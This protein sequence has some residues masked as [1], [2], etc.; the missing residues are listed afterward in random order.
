VQTQNASLGNAQIVLTRTPRRRSRSG[1]HQ[2]PGGT[3]LLKLYMQPC[4]GRPAEKIESDLLARTRASRPTWRSAQ[5]NGDLGSRNRHSGNRLF[6]CEG[7]AS[8]PKYLVGRW[9]D[10]TPIAADPRSAS[11]RPPVKPGSGRW[12]RDLSA[13]SRILRVPVAV[14]EENGQRSGYHAQTWRLPHGWACGSPAAAASAGDR[15]GS[16]STPR[17]VHFGM[18]VVMS[19]QPNTLAQ[20]FT[21]DVSTA[22]A[23]SAT[24]SASVNS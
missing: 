20:Q 9:N 22:W 1:R 5:R 4:A 6:G 21:V 3:G 17:W 10:L 13:R 14:R 2:D 12:S 11:S 18:R 19:Y 24:P 8:E 23:C 7:S 15:R 16:P